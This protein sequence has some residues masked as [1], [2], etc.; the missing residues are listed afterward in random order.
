MGGTLAGKTIASTYQDLLTLSSASDNDGI[1]SSLVKVEDGDGTDTALYLSTVAMAVDAT[2][3]IY[4]D[5]GNDT[6]IYE[7]APDIVDIYVGGA[8]LLKF[9]QG[10]AS[11]TEPD[12]VQIPHGVELVIGNSD[13]HFMETPDDHLQLVVGSTA[14]MLWDQDNTA[15]GYGT[16]EIGVDG[17]GCDMLWHSETPS[18]YMLYDQSLCSL[19][20]ND[21]GHA[22]SGNFQLIIKGNIG[23]GS[24]ALATAIHLESNTNDRAK[25]IMLSNTDDNQW[26]FAGVPYSTGSTDLFQIGYH[27]NSTYQPHYQGNSVLTCTSTGNVGIGQSVATYPLHITITDATNEYLAYFNHEGDATTC[28]GFRTRTG[29]DSG[30]AENRIVRFDDGDGTKVGEINF[31]GATVAYGTFTAHHKGKIPQSDNANGY[32]YG[33]LL[34]FESLFY[35]QKNG[36]DSER[37]IRYNMKKT[38]SAYTKSILGAYNSKATPDE[39][40]VDEN[41]VRLSAAAFNDHGVNVLGDGHILCNNEKGNIAIGDGITSSSTEGVGMKA[42]KTCMIVGI[43]QEAVTFSGSETKLVAVQYGVRQFTPW[44]D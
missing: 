18:G 34:E 32:P 17:E 27:N 3:K 15:G 22:D 37:G 12:R 19:L 31:T 43:A 9:T 30:S 28:K 39:D 23:G 25:G 10:V 6:Y 14:M 40:D 38:S 33:T 41:G 7:S 44:T 21:Q 26:W 36:G 8:N 16:I 13:T 20:I 2:D 35:V 5:G 42:D 1:T 24:P 11:G 29:E 4:L